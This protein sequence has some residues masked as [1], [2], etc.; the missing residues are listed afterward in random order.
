[1]PDHNPTFALAPGVQDQNRKPA[2]A[3]QHVTMAATAMEHDPGTTYN[4]ASLL[5][6]RAP[7]LTMTNGLDQ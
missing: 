4:P 5:E 1:M 3:A 7:F 2:H 6:N